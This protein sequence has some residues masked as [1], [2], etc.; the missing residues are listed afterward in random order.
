MPLRIAA[1]S[2]KGNLKAV[3]FKVT[4]VMQKFPVCFFRIRVYDTY[5]TTRKKW[6]QSRLFCNVRL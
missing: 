6:M 4:L 1:F 2:V 3:Q 5:S